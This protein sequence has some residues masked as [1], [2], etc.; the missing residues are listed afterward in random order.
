MAA[1]MLDLPDRGAPF[2]MTICP[3]D[4]DVSTIG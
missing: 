2:K 3:G 4:N 1:T